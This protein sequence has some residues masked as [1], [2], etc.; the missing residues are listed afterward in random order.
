MFIEVG[1]K[2][3]TTKLPD[4]LETKVY[5]QDKSWPSEKLVLKQDPSGRAKYR[6][7]F[8]YEGIENE[9]W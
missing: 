2:V 7:L 9:N 1:A 8:A 3:N 5:K 6:I 4:G